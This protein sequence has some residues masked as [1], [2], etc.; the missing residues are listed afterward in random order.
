MW[1]SL[2]EP[3]VSPGTL[4]VCLTGTPGL[5]AWLLEVQAQVLMFVPQALYQLSHPS[6]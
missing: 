2:D 3:A 6:P 1:T 4:R 5:R